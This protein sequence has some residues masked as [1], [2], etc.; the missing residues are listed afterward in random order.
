[1]KNKL[2]QYIQYKRILEE[3]QEILDALKQDIIAYMDGKDTMV[4]GY[5]IATYK[6]YTLTRIDSKALKA[7]DPSL[8]HKYSVQSTTYRFVVK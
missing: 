8:Y 3:T 6:P 1:M 5:H 2:E 7:A 4:A